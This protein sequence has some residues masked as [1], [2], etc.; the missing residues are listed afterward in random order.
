[1]RNLREKKVK[2]TT[3]GQVVE[4]ASL[5]AAADALDTKYQNIMNWVHHVT[6]CSIP[7]VTVEFA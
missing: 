1:M 2:V 6:K 3:N 4:Y 5:R 7:G